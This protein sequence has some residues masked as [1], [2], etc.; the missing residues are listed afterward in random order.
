LI[1]ERVAKRSFCGNAVEGFSLR[2]AREGEGF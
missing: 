2:T 1:G